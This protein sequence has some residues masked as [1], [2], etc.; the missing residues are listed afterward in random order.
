MG[1]SIG[2]CEGA[3]QVLDEDGQSNMVCII[4][5][6][7]FLHSGITPLL[8]MVFNKSNATVLIVDNWIT[9]MTGAQEHPGTGFTATGEETVSVDYAELSKA[10]GVAQD[11]IRSVDPYNIEEF[12]KVVKE[13]TS[14]WGSSEPGSMWLLGLAIFALS[15]ILTNWSMAVNP[16]FEKSVRIQTD[17]GHR[18][19]DTGPYAYIRHPGYTGF[20]GWII[21]TPLLLSSTGAFIPALI[22]VGLVVIRTVLEDHTLRAEL[23]GY[24][25]YANRVRFRLI[26]GVW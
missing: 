1:S 21:S 2:V 10:L 7:T 6:S 14:G 25:E 11:N 17:R 19:I 8:N 26:P 24:T 5:D 20:A 18:V 23:T 12:D 22:A 9:A 4:G 15:W 16:F 3:S 13:E